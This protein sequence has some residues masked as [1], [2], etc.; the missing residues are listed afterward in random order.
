MADVLFYAG[1]HAPNQSRQMDGV[2]NPNDM[3]LPYG[4]DWDICAAK[5]F[6]MLSAENGRIVAP[7]G[8]SYRLLVLP[9]LDTMSV[10]A[11]ENVGRL[12][13]AGVSVCG[14]AKPIRA[15]GLVGHP[16][17]SERV[18]EL[19]DRIWAKGVF[20]CTPAETLHRLGIAPDFGSDD[21]DVRKG[22]VYIHRRNESADWYFVACNNEQTK[23]VE[24][25]FREMGRLPEI[26]DAETGKICDAQRWHVENG[27]TVVQLSL[28][29]SGSV[30][31]V[32]RKPVDGTS[33]TNMVAT[34]EHSPVLVHGAWHVSFP[35]NWGAPESVEF[36]ELVSW[37]ERNES[38]IRFFSGTAS[39]VK[40]VPCNTPS[41]GERIILDLGVV[42]NFAVVTVN[43]TTF[44][45]LWRPPYRLDVTDALKPRAASFDLKVDITNLWPNRLIG[46]ECLPEDCEW[47]GSIRNGVREIGL[48]EIPDWVRCG[49]KS[50]AGRFTFTTWKHWGKGDK[51][52][53]SGLLGPVILQTIEK[54]K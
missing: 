33:S 37:T 46:D 1:E 19:A 15:P 42:K 13:D 12:M 41:A 7:G 32:F 11:L 39:Y 14:M 26:W 24:V 34:V 49:S 22:V 35:P 18:R 36:P 9:P 40:T 48:K 23:T 47:V 8:T 20:S 38:G 44:P 51:L 30:F 4:Y 52:L 25:N 3:K 50:P 27:R 53:L 5:P 43:N 6:E 10:H 2:K 21:C 45:V 28:P 17:A 16:G 29:P 54:V 31:V